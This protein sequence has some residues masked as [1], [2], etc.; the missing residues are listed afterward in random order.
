MLSTMD[1]GADD[2]LQYA[3]HSP[4]RYSSMFLTPQSTSE[5]ATALA[6]FLRPLQGPHSMYTNPPSPA[7]SITRHETHFW[8]S[9]LLPRPHNFQHL[10]LTTPTSKSAPLQ[11]SKISVRMRLFLSNLV[12]NDVYFPAPPPP[13]QTNHLNFEYYDIPIPLLS[14]QTQIQPPYMSTLPASLLLASPTKP[15]LTSIH[16]LPLIPT[17]PLQMI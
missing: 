3:K 6:V 13:P 17:S 10:I 7:E 12:F 5:P 16:P 9:I 14:P 1:F 11:L 4:P 15:R 8:R 2:D